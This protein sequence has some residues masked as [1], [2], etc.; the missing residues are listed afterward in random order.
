MRSWRGGEGGAPAAGNRGRAP[1]APAPVAGGA[2]AKAPAA[3]RP[4]GGPGADGGGA[5]VEA[6]VDALHDGR[7]GLDDDRPAA[8]VHRRV[9]HGPRGGGGGGDRAGD[10]AGGGE[11]GDAVRDLHDGLLPRRSGG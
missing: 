1:A 2:P 11:A 6:L 5:P 9:R 10:E 8:L 7:R 4:A 3:P